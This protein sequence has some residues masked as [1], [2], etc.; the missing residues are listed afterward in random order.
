MQ[1]GGDAG[2]A[3]DVE[4]IGATAFDMDHGVG[5]SRDPPAWAGSAAPDGKLIGPGYRSSRDRRHLVCGY[6]G[7]GCTDATWR[8]RD[9]RATC[10]NGRPTTNTITDARDSCQLHTATVYED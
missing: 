3:I 4:F 9:R 1:H 8:R 2:D 6:C 7:G 10:A 5:V